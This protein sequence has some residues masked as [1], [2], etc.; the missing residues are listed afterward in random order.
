VIKPLT[1]RSVKQFGRDGD[2]RI[3]GARHDQRRRSR[4]IAEN[5]GTNAH[6][7]LANVTPGRKTLAAWNSTHRWN[8]VGRP[9][10]RS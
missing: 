9:F 8:S 6:E 4:A 2:S 3:S 5:Y 7:V 1:L 10:A